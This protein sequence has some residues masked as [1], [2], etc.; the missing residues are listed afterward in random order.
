MSGDNSD[1]ARRGIKVISRS[2]FL[3]SQT[4]QGLIVLGSIPIP[5]NMLTSD[6][7]LC[8]KKGVGG[9]QPRE[10]GYLQHLL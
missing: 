8:D 1:G 3:D 7:V 6:L 9:S 5:S 2:V 4:Q 10:A